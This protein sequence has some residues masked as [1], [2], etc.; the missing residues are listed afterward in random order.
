MNKISK[1][2]NLNLVG[3]VGDIYSIDNFDEF[4]IILL[5]SMFHFAKKD[6]QKEIRLVQKIV[7]KIKDGGLLVVC[8]QDTGNKV[9]ILKQS[10]DFE[11]KCNQLADKKFKYTFKEQKSGHKSET[12]YRMI[13]IE[14]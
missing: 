14:K 11:K 4:N 12:N 10:M 13:V 7:S 2:E 9:K 3:R 6:K 8:I 1:A 5:D